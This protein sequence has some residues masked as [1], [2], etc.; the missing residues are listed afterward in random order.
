MGN[1]LSCQYQQDFLDEPERDERVQKLVEDLRL[2][3]LN[4]KR[5]TWDD[6]AQ[7]VPTNLFR[8]ERM[9]CRVNLFVSAD[10]SHN[11]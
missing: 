3:D 4:I 7:S 1:A 2:Q 10:R 6:D 9:T 11:S 5:E 8:P